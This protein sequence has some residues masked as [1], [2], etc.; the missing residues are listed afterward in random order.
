MSSRWYVVYTQAHSEAQAA[1]HL[2]RQG[3]DIY[4]PRQ[5]KLCRHARKTQEKL[6]PL[7][8]RYLF[9]KVDTGVQRWRAINSTLGV[10][11]LVCNG[12]A[13]A[14]LPD[15]ALSLLKAREGEDGVINMYQR[16]F[17]AGERV[18]VRDGIF[19][20]LTGLV[21]AC[22]DRERIT[23]LLDLLGRKARVT[24]PEAS[25]EAT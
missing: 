4:L 12:D 7:F 22:T 6:T 15:V 20:A 23:I 14:P 18:R 5:R 9:V 10:M 8:P 3:F 19:A 17:R 16:L 21:E 13:P 24:L 2:L 11:H 25:L 1:F